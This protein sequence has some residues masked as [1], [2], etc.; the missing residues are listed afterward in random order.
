[1][2]F[3]C[4]GKEIV[5]S[6]PNGADVAVM[7]ELWN[8]FCFRVGRLKTQNGVQDRIGFGEATYLPIADGEEYTVCIR[9]EG[10]G[11]VG[12]DH[13]SLM[14]AFGAL[15]ARIELC[16]GEKDTLCLPCG[17]I[18]GVYSVARRMIHLCVFPETDLSML[19][20]LVRLCGVLSYTHVVLEFWGMLK[21][22]C[23]H[24]L[25]WS[26]AFS[27][28][29]IAPVI[30]EARAMGMEPIPM[31]NH[32]GHASS[33]RIDTGKHVVLD[34]NPALQY[35]F[36]P[37]GWC[38]DIFSQDVRALLKEMRRELCELFGEGEYF[39][40]GC[41]EAHIYSSEYYP[42]AGLCDY[43]ASLTREVLSEGRRPILWGD[44]IVPYDC[45][46]EKPEKAVAA[47]ERAKRMKPLMDA[48][49]PQSVIA[50]WHYDI[51]TAPVPSV[52]EFARQGFDVMGC[53]WDQPANIDAQHATAVGQKTYGLM[54]TT[55]HTM[56]A[57]LS[58]ILYFAR[59]CGFPKARWSDATGHRNLEIAILLRK[60]APTT[61][62]YAECG[63][64]HRQTKEVID[65]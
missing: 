12:R 45:S 21:Y 56:H 53:P 38:W 1:M 63:F 25:A 7:Q 55:W 15:L 5:A 39:H 14:R 65:W 16:A 42:M 41:D 48:L 29:Q 28:E 24:E 59:K 11:L 35:L 19:R 57:N 30:R 2:E 37:D 18:R 61:L 10:I 64:A 27:K 36:T 23:L 6:V 58:A 49:A 22:D 3:Y 43:L 32:L 31:I 34:Q 54:M 26:N 20:R 44:M 40:I 9:P 8:G 4:F 13:A 62:P 17:E 47:W 33:C 51:K 52:P 46:S 60:V 50:D